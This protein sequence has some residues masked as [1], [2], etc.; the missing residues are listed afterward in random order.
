MRRRLLRSNLLRPL[1]LGLLALTGLL[2][3]SWRR[4]ALALLGR[5]RIVLALTLFDFLA[6]LFQNWPFYCASALDMLR[7]R[8]LANNLGNRL[9]RKRSARGSRNHVHLG[10]FINDDATPRALEIPIDPTNVINDARAIDDRSVIYDDRVRT[11]R[12]AEMMNVHE[13]EQ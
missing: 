3:T 4:R 12:L 8:G 9:G 5:A 13:H 11:D 10:S 1:V 2:T 7:N 6:V